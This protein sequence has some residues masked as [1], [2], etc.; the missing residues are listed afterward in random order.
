MRLYLSSQRLGTAPGELVSLLDGRTRIAVIANAA[1]D[2]PPTKR[3]GR[4]EREIADLR[5]IGLDPSEIDLDHLATVASDHFGEMDLVRS[6]LEDFDA[7]WVLGG[8]VVV[9]RTAFHESGADEVIGD[10]LRDDSIVFAGYSAGPC[11][12]GPRAPL[13]DEVFEGGLEGYPDTFVTTGL[14]ILPFA[15]APHYGREPGCAGGTPVADHYIDNHIPFIALRDGQ[16]LVIDGE[17]LRVVE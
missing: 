14:E 17:I 8:N 13:W 12:L 1:D 4:V 3:R 11:M 16:A 10:R 15:I 5:E 2:V 9:L 6:T 7:V